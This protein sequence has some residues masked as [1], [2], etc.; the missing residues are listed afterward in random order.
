MFQQAWAA[1]WEDEAGWS[2]GDAVPTVDGWDG[3]DAAAGCLGV[4]A[5]TSLG[6]FF[7]GGTGTGAISPGSNQFHGLIV[8]IG[9]PNHSNDNGDEKT[10][11]DAKYPPFDRRPVARARRNV[12]LFAVANPVFLR[13][14][15]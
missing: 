2:V 13:S 11:N 15:A 12:C 9:L 14:A 8:P 1:A 10:A 3:P 6:T 4:S 7:R 5:W